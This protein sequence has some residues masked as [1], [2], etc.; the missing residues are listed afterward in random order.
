MEKSQTNLLIGL[1]VGSLAVG[2]GVFAY[3]KLGVSADGTSKLPL[4]RGSLDG[5]NITCTAATTKSDS[6]G[7]KGDDGTLYQGDKKLLLDTVN[8]KD[9]ADYI[10]YDGK[11]FKSDGK[12]YDAKPVV[13][14]DQK[15]FKNDDGKYLLSDGK[16]VAVAT[17]FTGTLV[18]ADGKIY[19]KGDKA[20]ASNGPVFVINGQEIICTTDG[21][22]VPLA[23]DGKGIKVLELTPTV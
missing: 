7:I 19:Q 18:K 2:G 14:A 9:D 15:T 4:L 16:S 11:I 13:T 3:S 17:N 1:A 10:K 23:A 20:L 5:R 6:K 12:K 22:A 8:V 21:R